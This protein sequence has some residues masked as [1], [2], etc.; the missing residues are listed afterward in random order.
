MR[1][2][3]AAREA[4]TLIEVMVGIGLAG[5]LV[6]LVLLLGTTA[7]STDA[8]ASERQIAAAVAEGQLELLC[9]R[10]GLEGGPERTAF[11]GSGDGLYSGPGTR[12]EVTSNG[13]VYRLEYRLRTLQGPTGG[14][15]GGPAN[16]LR[17]VQLKIT[18]WQGEQGK[19]GYG[20]FSLRRTRLLRESNVRA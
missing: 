6:L 10:A 11:W 13:T 8:K 18:W 7:V 3:A 4:F 2:L 14:A 20:Q 12:S 5:A 9:R 17:Q 19:P 1:R 16:R 15:I